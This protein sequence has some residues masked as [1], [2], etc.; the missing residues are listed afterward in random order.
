[1]RNPELNRIASVLTG[2]DRGYYK[3]PQS[4]TAARDVLARVEGAVCPVSTVGE[5]EALRTLTGAI[6]AAGRDSAALWPSPD[7]VAEARQADAA[8]DAWRTA[9]GNAVEIAGGE[10]V[11][12]V[13]DDADTIITES[14]RPALAEVLAEVERHVPDFLPVADFTDR[15][16][17]A[18]A[19][20]GQKA[21][22][23]L[24]DLA[25]RYGALRSVQEILSRGR[26]QADTDG[27]FREVRNLQALYGPQ[28]AGRNQ[29]TYKPWPADPRQRMA[30]LA[31]SE[32]D[33]WMPTPG[34]RDVMWL[35]AYGHRS[36]VGG[37]TQSS[38]EFVGS[39]R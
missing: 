25:E 11:G 31:T 3:L 37:L 17:L 29:N 18:A 30:W 32:A 20:K 35:A 24:S 22:L 28:W 7:S 15:Q 2:A 21:A 34:D 12:A 26:V 6:L 19:T 4:V 10:L 14:L 16:L 39:E 1:M 38:A 8:V 23:A 5:G 9:H 36:A 27:I 33:V 13:L